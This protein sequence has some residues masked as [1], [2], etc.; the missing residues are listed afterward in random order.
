MVREQWTSGNCWLISSG[1]AFEKKIRMD[2]IRRKYHRGYM[3][4]SRLRQRLLKYPNIFRFE[5][6]FGYRLQAEVIENGEVV[7]VELTS[8][9]DV[10]AILLPQEKAVELAKWLQIKIKEQ[11]K[12][13]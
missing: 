3:R 9:Q 11:V 4:A 2:S 10:F 8:P 13:G 12:D 7:K 6:G 5:K 1:W